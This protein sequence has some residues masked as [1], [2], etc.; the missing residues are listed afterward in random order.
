[1]SEIN[2]FVESTNIFTEYV[3]YSVPHNSHATTIGYKV[4]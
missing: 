1:M 2:V 3:L 4:L